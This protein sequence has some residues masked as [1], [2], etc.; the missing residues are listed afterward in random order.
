MTPASI[1][2]GDTDSCTV[3]LLVTTVRY[4]TIEVES[5]NEAGGN[6]AKSDDPGVCEP[7]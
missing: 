1:F 4:G 5:D 6:F 2:L 7:V 3:N